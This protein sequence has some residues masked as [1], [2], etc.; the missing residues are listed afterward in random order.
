[1][2]TTVLSD[3]VADLRALGLVAWPTPHLPD[4][5]RTPGE[6]LDRW[7]RAAALAEPDVRRAAIWAIREAARAGG[8][9]P[10]S[11]QGLYAARGQGKWGGRTVPA[12]NLRGWTYQTCRAAFR[13]A[14]KLA[15]DLLIFEQAPLE[16]AYASQRPA[17]YTAAVLAA[18]MREGH[19]GPIFLQAD[20]VQVNAAS[21]AKDPM[22]EIHRLTELVSEQIAASFFNIDIDA[23]TVVDLSLPTLVD[24]QRLNAEL[25]AHFTRLVRSMEPSRVTVSLGAEIGEVGAHN[26]TPDELRA[27]MRTYRALTAAGDVGISKVSVNSG[28]VHGGKV[29][30]DGSLA[31][32]QVDF[33]TLAAISKAGRE[34]FGISGAVQHGASTL[35][36]SLFN[37]FP[38]NDT[39]EIH[40]A[41]GFNNLIFDHPRLPEA[42]KQEIRSYVFTHHA[43]ERKPGQTDAQFLY[44]T[45]KKAW[46]VMKERFFDLPEEIQTV[47]GDSLEEMFA[48]MFERLKARDT[49]ELVAQFTQAPAVQVPV[50]PALAKAFEA[51]A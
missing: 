25:T 38:E 3:V 50:P 11:I 5:T 18:A 33:D 6:V 45:R 48:Q 36:I 9:H 35:P 22:A 28:T 2:G 51:S 42:V 44:T 20:H 26:T 15:A 34:E 31:E 46:A 29:L 39:V 47:I 4:G 40:L 41:L 21:Y 13:A 10:A 16:I 8:L 17:E 14:R 23:S 12:L 43:G 27:F 30:P 49:R 7:A 32:I 37:R 24:Q 19:R 1:M